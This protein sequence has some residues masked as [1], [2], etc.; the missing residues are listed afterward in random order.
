MKARLASVPSS[1][2]VPALLLAGLTLAVYAPVRGHGFV[3]YDDEVYVA[4]NEHVK[5]GLTGPSVHWALT[6][7]HMG[8]WHP[9][10]MLS[11][12]ADV[13]LFG[14]DAGTHHVT[15]LALHV[16]NVLLL[17]ALLVRL[18]GL[19]WRSAFAAG[20]FAFH[21][22]NVQSVAWISERK[23]L[24]STAFWF[25]ALLAYVGYV[26]RGGWSRYLLVTVLFVLG[27]ASKAMLVMLPVTLLLL[28]IWK[29]R[30]A[31]AEGVR[32]KT[33]WSRLVLEKAPLLALSA[34]CALLTV[35]AQADTGAAQTLQDY[36]VGVRLSNASVAYTWYLVKAIWPSDLHVFYP[37][38]MA[39]LESWRVAASA[40]VLI[41][42]SVGVGLTG[43]RLPYLFFGWAWYLS[44]LLPVIGL[45]QVGSQAYA[46][47]YAYVPLVGPFV[48]ATWGLADAAAAVGP[49]ARRALAGAGAAA[50]AAY[51]LVASLQV[52]YWRDGVTLFGRAVAVDPGNDVTRGN[53][54]IAL[55]QRGRLDEAIGH[56]QAAVELK[57]EAAENHLNLGN[58]FALTGRH[59]QARERYLEAIRLDLEDPRARFNLGKLLADSGRT[60]E[61][62]P[63]LREAIR[64]DPDHLKAR[65]LLD[66]LSADARRREGGAP[67]TPEVESPGTGSKARP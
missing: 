58:A 18:S 62:L 48:A 63:H 52:G 16:V 7:P 23:N 67:I 45:I 27:L 31:R 2:W 5:A 35:Q 15:N 51:A 54:G 46:D 43:A 29:V 55:A 60:E 37:H 34:A 24:L 38:P 64:L 21:P 9:L 14:L 61:A 47:R 8:N 11:H 28:D 12:M 66:R 57:P 40:A 56:F 10:T 65:L 26:R 3:N 4:G 19:P 44:T 32:G 53:L 33:A 30:T 50:L 17:F 36:P 25:L 41:A 22:L 20:L 39:G 1:T 49:R 6:T 59:A 42:V 13:Q